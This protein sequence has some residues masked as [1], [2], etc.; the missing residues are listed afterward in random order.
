[1]TAK[2]YLAG[3]DAG[4]TGATV[5]IVDTEG[6]VV[7]SAYR[8]YPCQYPHPGWVEQ[9]M[10]YMWGKI[11]EA[12]QEALA[13]TGV[14]PQEIASVGF[15][16]QRGSF[17]CVDSHVTPLHNSI[18][19]ND[20]RANE[21]ARTVAERIGADRY[22]QITGMPLSALWSFAK[23]RW[24]I[25]KHPRLLEKTAKI[26]NGQEFFLHKLGA[27]ELTSD[28]ASLTL[29]GM[30]D[31]D[32]LDWS[33]EVCE[34]IELP[35]EKLP[36]MT[37]PGSQVGTISRKA[38]EQT[39]FAEGMPIC[40]GGGDQQCAAVGSGVIREGLAEITIG[41]AAMVV[42]HID[43]RKTDP[44]RLV[45]IGG[46]AI[47]NKWDMEG[48]AFAT[49]VCLRWWRDVYG[50]IEVETA[51][52]L[53]LDAYNLIAAQAASAPPGCK[54][55]LFFPFFTGQVTPSYNSNARGGSL[56]L[57]LSH[58][59][60]SMAR[61][62]LEGG[63]YELRMVV[64]S[65]EAVLG[66]PFDILRLTGGGAKSALWTQIQ[67]D[68]YGRHVETLKVSE[69]TTLGAAILGGLGA[70]VFTSVEEAVRTMVHSDR[71]IEPD[72]KNHQLYSELYELFVLTYN[73]LVNAGIYEK[74]ADI[75]AKY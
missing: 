3:I 7:G 2:K 39:G 30:L 16:S 17:V 33:T 19:W 60:A 67:A 34:A 6:G 62:V 9:D 66:K 46:H 21:Q 54:G 23:I 22:H 48:G 57:S 29:N 38:A 40:R 58:D 42:A 43:S 24:L 68:I 41:T 8:E 59:R 52:R 51:Q 10:E 35:V 37:T 44:K 15:S 20:G 26:V 74:L 64:S 56:G 27:E 14:G 11:C 49:G 28:P 36:P 25:E 1:M 47:P 12:S 75:Q 70:G 18:V 61:A 53:G 63:A 65:M 72:L 31:I 69:C 4:T 13:K 71:A 73:T 5:M 45:Y 55:L 50:Q 32:Q